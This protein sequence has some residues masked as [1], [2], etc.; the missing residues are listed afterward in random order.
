MTG[1]AIVW[2][3]LCSSFADLTQL[4]IAHIAADT[5]RSVA[6]LVAAGVAYLCP[7]VLTPADADSYGAILVSVI[8]LV[9]LIPLFQGI[10]RIWH[11]IR[12]AHELQERHTL[13]GLQV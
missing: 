4:T 1:C 12:V 3:Y 11:K 5:L 9:S 10:G 13:L 7:S 8:I 2:V 6:V